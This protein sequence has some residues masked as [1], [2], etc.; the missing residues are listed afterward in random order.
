MILKDLLTP[1]FEDWILEIYDKNGN[2]L[3]TTY[4]EGLS[5][6]FIRECGDSIVM[7]TSPTEV[8][9]FMTVQIDFKP[10]EK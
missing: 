8:K 6:E 3:A 5:E 1:Q 2:Y 7:N 4:E 10:T 9:D